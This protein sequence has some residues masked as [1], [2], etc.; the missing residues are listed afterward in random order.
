MVS[1]E[2]S[3]GN[4]SDAGTEDL[5]SALQVQSRYGTRARGII[6][7]GDKGTKLML[8]RHQSVTRKCQYCILIFYFC[9]FYC[10]GYPRRVSTA[11]FAEES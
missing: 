7:L 1:N 2:D 8:L 10:S 3:E 4:E 6:A 11:R 5:E 9:L